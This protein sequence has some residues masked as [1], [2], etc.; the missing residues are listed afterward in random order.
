MHTA[1]FE[2]IWDPR[3]HQVACGEAAYPFHSR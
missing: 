1:R 2:M 3:L